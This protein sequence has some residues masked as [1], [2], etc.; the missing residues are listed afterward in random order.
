MK[1]C[2][3]CLV[4]RPLSQFRAHGGRRCKPCLYAADAERYHRKR[5]EGWRP[6]PEDPAK[7]RARTA[8]YHAANPDKARAYVNARRARLANAEGQHTD[9]EWYRLVRRYRGC[10]YCGSTAPLT[11]DHVVPLS[12]GGSDFI[13]NIVPACLS[14][15]CS[16]KD[17]LLMEWRLTRASTDEPS[18]GERPRTPRPSH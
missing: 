8:R 12:R 3:A 11:R 1:T 14:C 18:S 10:A 5:A 2:S 15:N 17:R 6:R 4:E 13:G 7:K 9:R 16:K